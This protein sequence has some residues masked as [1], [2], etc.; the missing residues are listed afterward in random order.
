MPVI[1]NDDKVWFDE[2]LKLEQICKEVASAQAGG[3]S[4]LLLSHF[5]ATLSRLA[6]LLRNKGVRFEKFSSLNPAELCL[7]SPA[8]VW[9]GSARAFRVTQELTSTT[10][11][12]P[13][14]VIV[15][16]H[17][18]IQSKDQE[19][20]AAAAKLSCNG[21]LCFYFSLDDSL[22]RHFGADSIKAL[23]ERLDIDKTECISHHLINT[24]I[25]TAQEKIES[26]V[27][28]DVPTHSAEDWFKYN[29]RDK[30]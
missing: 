6:E 23:F 24:A 12:A 17:H 22:M 3:R 1:L 15:A 8:R 21:E 10:V 29:L 27:G 5:E 19:I 25:R 18:P 26:Q 4:V 13:L 14:Q 9:L 11:S 30:N 28:K 2:S 20:V 7:R 16:E